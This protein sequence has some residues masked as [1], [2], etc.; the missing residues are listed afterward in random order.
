[1]YRQPYIPEPI[2]FRDVHIDDFTEEECWCRF[3]FRK[4]HLHDLMF[5]LRIHEFNGIL[6]N[7]ARVSPEKAFL[8]TLHRLHCPGNLTDMQRAWGKEYS[9]L[10]RIF[11][12]MIL[13]LH[14]QHSYLIKDNIA[15]FVPWFPL[16]NKLIK[17]RIAAKNNGVVP[18]ELEDIAVF[19]DGTIRPI[20]KPSKNNNIQRCVYNGKDKVHALKFQ[21]LSAPDGMIIDMYGPVAGRHHDVNMTGESNTSAICCRTGRSLHI[22]SVWRQKVYGNGLC[23]CCIPRNFGC[24]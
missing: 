3:R 11:K 9:Q 1:M 8:F 19:V 5:A 14:D 2:P 7:R 21:G 23:S 22:Q 17:Q 10:S 6:E 4:E 16:Y 13:F 20:C 24:D 18:E 12:S 15:F